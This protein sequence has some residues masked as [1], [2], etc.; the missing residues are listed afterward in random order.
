[1]IVEVKYCRKE[2]GRWVAG[3]EILR[4]QSPIVEAGSAPLEQGMKEAE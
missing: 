1:V 3:C 4:N 2:E